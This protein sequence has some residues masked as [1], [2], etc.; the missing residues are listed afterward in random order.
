MRVQYPK[1]GARPP[2]LTKKCKKMSKLKR[3]FYLSPTIE[4]T[5]EVPKFYVYVSHD[6]E[7]VQA[8]EFHEEKDKER[9]VAYSS[10]RKPWLFSL[11][12]RQ[13]AINYILDCF[14]GTRRSDI[15]KAKA[16]LNQLNVFA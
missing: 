13:W 1:Q 10:T 3:K 4:S 11:D 16:E 6:G 15:R 9:I 7:E 2:V 5:E 12:R 14:E 8:G